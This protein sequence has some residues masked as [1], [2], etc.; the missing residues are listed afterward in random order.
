[1]QEDDDA[2]K[3]NVGTTVLLTVF[4][5]PWFSALDE[6]CFDVTIVFGLYLLYLFIKSVAKNWTETKTATQPG[7]TQQVFYESLGGGQIKMTTASRH[8]TPSPSWT[9]EDRTKTAIEIR[10]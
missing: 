9:L 7:Y 8:N 3:N 5:S 1:M 2:D 10:K 6:R 4:V